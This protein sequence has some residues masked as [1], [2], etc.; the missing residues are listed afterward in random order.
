MRLSGTKLRAARQRAALSQE[1]LWRASGV[2]E[3]T[4]NRLEQDKQRARPSTIRDLANALGITP[5]T[6]MVP[7]RDQQEDTDE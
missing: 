2:A 5:D 3:A 4:I 7:D 6:L 1:D